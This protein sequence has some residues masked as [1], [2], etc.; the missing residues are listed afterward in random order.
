MGQKLATI[1]TTRGR[2]GL[3][4]YVSYGSNMRADRFTCYLAGGT[5]AGA[6]RCYP[7]CRDPSPPRAARGCEVPGGVYF[8]T[9]SLVWGGGRA[10][11]DTGLPGVAAT[12]A[13]LIT[14]SQFADVAAQEMG[15]RPG[16]DLVLGGVLATGRVQ[17]GPGRYETLLY[18]G[19]H[20]GH[21]MLTF[22]APWTAAEIDHV[23][24]SAAY[25]RMLAAGLRE[26]HGWSAHRVAGYLTGLPGCAGAWTEAA[27]LALDNAGPA[28]LPEAADKRKGRSPDTAENP[29]SGEL[30]LG[31]VT[32]Q[33]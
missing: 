23:V 27:I 26:A 19:D 11:Y 28:H 10:F 7:G 25:L 1:A 13:Y 6:S 12:R 2:P 22:T 9:Q 24:P 8:A 18:L 4:W 20:G 29:A 14:E 31:P 3:V 32:Y 17:L 33:K 5:P 21:P 16:V 15:R 30:R